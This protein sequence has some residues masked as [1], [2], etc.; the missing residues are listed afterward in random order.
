[1]ISQLSSEPDKEPKAKAEKS[2]SIQEMRKE[3]D[4]LARQKEQSD[5]KAAEYLERLQRLQ[6]DM[7]NLQKIT[8]RNVDTITK[9]ASERLLVKLLPTLDS[10]QQAGNLVQSSDSLPPDEIVL[11]LKMLHKQLTE[12]LYSEGLEEIPAV[13]HP[14][15]PEVHEVVSYLESDGKPENTV[16]EE[17]R[18]GYMLNGKVV[19]PSLVVVTKPKLPKEKPVD[20]RGSE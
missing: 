4:E 5:K 2:Q 18:R 20:E 1:M 13:G 7:E 15:D 3:L 10:L 16:V 19:R 11:G 8:K 17:V 12:V 9:Q 14:L 6:A